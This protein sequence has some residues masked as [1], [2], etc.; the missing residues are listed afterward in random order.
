[1]PLE[2]P[3]TSTDPTASQ[4]PAS[5]PSAPESPVSAGS[6]G[7]GQSTD[8]GATGSSGL[9][10]QGQAGQVQVQTPQAQGV[11]AALK[12][13]GIDGFA[14]EHTALQQLALSHRRA[15]QQDGLVRYGQLYLQHADQFNAYLRQQQEQARQQQQP[16]PPSWWKA[17]EFKP[18]WRDAVERDEQGNYR[19][20]QGYA[21]DTLAKLQE[22]LSHQRTF[23]DKFSF[24]PIGTIKPGIE[25]VV[26]E[27]AQQMIQQNFGQYQEQQTAHQIADSNPWIFQRDAQGR[28]V[29]SP[30]GRPSLTP[31][32][33]RYAHYIGMAEQQ[34]IRD[35]Q[36]QD[37]FAR[38][39][40]ERDLLR[41]QLQQAG[42]ATQVASA[43]QQAKDQ[44]LQNQNRPNVAGSIPSGGPGV[45]PSQNTS[46]GLKERLA[47]SFKQAG[48]TVADQV[49]A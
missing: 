11:L 32:G 12:G 21:P 15:Q 3:V 49:V 47:N 6:S 9:A 31:E 41:A 14:D 25:Q 13:Y 26:K 39:M 18:E 28:K 17:P 23:L 45:K 40:V 48:Y 42:Q 36:S 38:S 27:V 1:M 7:L 29:M 5:G 37:T 2:V 20:K 30:E 34:G 8:T 4:A 33:Q 43:N 16:A 44:F 24:D 46:L 35:V 22:G 10:D 19:V